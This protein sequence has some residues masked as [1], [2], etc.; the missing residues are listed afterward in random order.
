MHLYLMNWLWPILYDY[1]LLTLL[2]SLLL[3]RDFDPTVVVVH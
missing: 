2:S 1:D 3:D